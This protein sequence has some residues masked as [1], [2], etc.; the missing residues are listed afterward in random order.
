M[1]ETAIPDRCLS[2][3][4]P[5][6][7]EEA[8]VGTVIRKLLEL[9]QLLEI[10]VVDDCSTDDTPSILE[11]L[12]TGNTRIVLVRHDAN[13]GK[14]EALKTGFR[15]TRGDVVIVQDADLE[16]DPREIPFIIAP[17]IGGVADVV[18]GSRFQMGRTTH[19]LYPHLYLG[20]KCLTFLSNLATKLALTDVE[21]CYKAF[22]GDIIRQMKLNSSGF[23]FEIEVTAKVAKLRC[24]VCEI[25]I[26]YSGRTYQEG[27]KMSSWDGIAALIYILRYNPFC[28]LTNSFHRPPQLGA[29][30]ARGRTP[31]KKAPV[32]A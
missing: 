15:L 8:T 5:V 20:N 23:G 13:Q 30:P 27:K 3:V 21:T 29:T 16:Y 12:C 28:S 26:T 7:N 6:F 17:I 32:E 2:V 31:D 18:F 10:V 4:V 14:T 11:S 24:A 22:R 25:P 1:I 19:G 9:S